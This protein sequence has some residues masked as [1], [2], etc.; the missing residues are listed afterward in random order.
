M[1]K[2]KIF[3]FTKIEFLGFG[4]ISMKPDVVILINADYEAEN[5]SNFISSYVVSIP[6]LAVRNF[7]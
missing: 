5:I 7:S 4:Y 2:S 1:F 6:N 3:L